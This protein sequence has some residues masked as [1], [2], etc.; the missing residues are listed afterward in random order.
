MRISGGY[1]PTSHR[2][3]A[4]RVVPCA[5]LRCL[6]Q[7]HRPIRFFIIHNTKVDG[8]DNGPALP[9]ALPVRPPLASTDA[10]AVRLCALP[11]PSPLPS[12]AVS[13]FCAGPELLSLSTALPPSAVPKAPPLPPSSPPTQAMLKLAL[14]AASRTRC[15]HPRLPLPLPAAPSP[16]SGSSGSLRNLRVILRITHSLDEGSG[17]EMRLYQLKSL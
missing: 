7:Q 12:G 8:E 14:S 15:M 6:V 1:R 10:A 5:T 16:G 13:G 2:K 3:G 17:T 9:L 11:S 4:R